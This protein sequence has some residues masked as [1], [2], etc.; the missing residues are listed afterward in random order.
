MHNARPVMRC[1]IT[2]SAG[3]YRRHKAI[4]GL[5]QRRSLHELMVVVGHFQRR[6]F[7][8]WREEFPRS[9]QH[10]RGL[11]R[12]YIVSDFQEW[13]LLVNQSTWSLTAMS[14]NGKLYRY[15]SSVRRASRSTLSRHR[16]AFL[17]TGFLP[18]KLCVCIYCDLLFGWIEAVNDTV[19]RTS[20]STGRPGLCG[21]L[22][23]GNRILAET[24]SRLCDR[25]WQ[26]DGFQAVN[27]YPRCGLSQ[28]DH[29]WLSLMCRKKCP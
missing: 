7:N 25:I 14:D 5:W 11:V 29:D 19:R 22:D 18:W 20:R 4:L 12:G 24:F 8:V 10:L 9:C 17:R 27:R 1:T 2:V 21:P 16:R 23:L 6:S 15:H 13:F 26:S 3:T 28:K